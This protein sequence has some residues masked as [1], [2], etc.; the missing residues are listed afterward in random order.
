MGW[1]VRVSCLLALVGCPD[2]AERYDTGVGLAGPTVVEG[3]AVYLSRGRQ[4]AL[5][6]EPERADFT[7]ARLSGTPLGAGI[8]VPG[9][10]QLAVL[11][12]QSETLD[13]INVNSGLVVT[14]DLH[15][16]FDGLS[17]SDDGGFALTSFAGGGSGIL[18]NAAEVAVV[19]LTAD[20]SDDNPTTRTIASAGG[21][22]TGIDVSP[23]FGPGGRRIALVRSTNH[24]AAIDLTQPT[25]AT[26]SIPLVSPGSGASVTPQQVVFA[27]Q[28]DTLEVFVRVSGLNDIYHLSFDGSSNEDGAPLPILNQFAAGVSPVDLA[29]WRGTDDRLRVLSVNA[30]SRDMTVI[31]VESAQVTTVALDTAVNKVLM[32]DGASGTR[33]ALIYSDGGASAQFH[34]VALEDLAVKKSKAVSTKSL[35]SAIGGIETVA[36]G[37]WFLVTH[38]GG[39]TA[40]TLVEG[41]GNRIMPFTSS[42]QVVDQMVTEDGSSIFLL[43]KQGSSTQLSV[44]DVA[45]G[46][47]ETMNLTD[48]T[49]AKALHRL[50]AADFILIDETGSAGALTLV[51]GADIEDG[52]PT[53]IRGFG[54]AG[55]LDEEGVEE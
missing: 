46:H 14:Y 31:D 2:R 53:L 4:A 39:S 18:S 11:V 43:T 22:P 50:A 12:P 38:S 34:R 37:A 20:P 25:G 44:I 27:V 36:G 55:I 23:P 6:L 33:E 47:P 52:E 13:I 49:S 35:V 41:A 19:D 3:R 16:G 45:T 1:I 10:S 32:Y 42:A 8:E 7:V 54:L 21:A 15:S 29:T 28:A 51:R 26:R 9:Q 17:L 24:L 48:V 5:I 40:V 30:G